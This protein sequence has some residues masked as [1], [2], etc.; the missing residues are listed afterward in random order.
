MAGTWALNLFD[1][2][3]LGHEIL[4]ERLSQKHDPT[5]AV[6]TGELI[7]HGLE[8][9]SIIQSTSYRVKKVT[10]FLESIDLVDKIEVKEIHRYAEF[11]EIPGKT[12]FMM[13]IGPCCTDLEQ[14][15]V[16]LRKT[17]LGINDEIEYLKPVRADDGK[18]LSSARIRKG[19]IDPQ[20]HRLRGT[21]EPPRRLDTRTRKG[22]KTPKGTVYNENDC[23]PEKEVAERIQKEEPQCVVAVGDVT[24]ATLM[25]ED[26]IPDVSIVD[27]KTKRGPFGDSFSGEKEYHAYNP[28][29]MLYPEAWSVI[30][31]A[32]H[33]NKKSIVFIEGEE[34]LMGFPAAV[35]APQ[36]SVM[37][38]GQPDVGIV[39]VPIT[40]E[41][42]KLA[43]QFLKAMPEING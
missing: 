31:T 25:N 38:Y 36:G 24:S 40:A 37:L 43:K 26:C 4:L 16:D 23:I 28:A 12:K 20:G 13:Y 35:L 32:I 22:L 33:D 21:E 30:D 2:L 10:E 5:A 42:V 17:Q 7:E 3:H 8:L 34:D 15:G 41:N 29:G 39:W 11:L 27:G 6:T 1:R 9:A 14:H 18:K 19:K